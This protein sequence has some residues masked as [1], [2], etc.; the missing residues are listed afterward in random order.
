MGDALMAFWGAP[1]H[2]PDHA[3]HAIEAALDMSN[4]A[5][6]LRAQ[7]VEK[8]WPEIRVGV[9]VSTGAMSVGNMGSEFRMAYTVLGDAVNLGARL[10]GLTKMPGYPGIIVSEITANAIPDHAFRELDQV[11][12]VGKSEPV[13]IFEPLGET[14][15]LTEQQ[16]KILELL[17][18]ALQNYR[19]QQWDDAMAVFRDLERFGDDELYRIYMQRID[20]FRKNPPGED[21]DGTFIHQSK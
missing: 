17:N 19:L 16:Q 3:R 12:V 2:D 15:H 13:G 1:L 18:P 5:E 6:E 10:E 8:G 11:Q 4:K 20:H 14:A 21:W 7:F 9:G